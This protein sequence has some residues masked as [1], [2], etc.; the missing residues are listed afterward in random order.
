MDER[1]INRLKGLM[2]LCVRAGHAVFGEDSCMKEIREE[3]AALLLMDESISEN[4]RQKVTPLCDRKGVPVFR[5]QPGLLEESTGR[6]GKV[7]LVRTGGFAE[8]MIRLADV[9][10]GPGNK[11]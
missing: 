7:M 2:G 3:R 9:N 1:S 8:Q 4:S 11:V 5:L 10:A 6:P